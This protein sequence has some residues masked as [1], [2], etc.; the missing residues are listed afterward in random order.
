LL[1][2]KPYRTSEVWFLLSQ[3][4]KL[5]FRIG[6]FGT[7]DW[8]NCPIRRVAYQHILCVVFNTDL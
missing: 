7:K 3:R 5:I 6:R 4:V 2:P 1:A 8:A